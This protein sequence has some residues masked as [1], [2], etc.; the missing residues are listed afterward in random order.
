MKKL[1]VYEGDGEVLVCRPADEKHLLKEW[2]EKGG[3]AVDDYTRTEI[4]GVL[5]ITSRIHAFQG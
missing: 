4:K 1:I 5:E 3:R 2:F